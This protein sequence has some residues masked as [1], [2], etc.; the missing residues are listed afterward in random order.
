MDEMKGTVIVYSR[1][2]CK[3]S[4][5]AKNTLSQLGL[6]YLDISLDAFPKVEE[7]LIDLVGGS[8]QTP[9]IFF[10][11]LRVSGYRDLRRLVASSDA[12]LE[13]LEMLERGEDD[14]STVETESL[15]TNSTSNSNETKHST[16]E[17]SDALIPDNFEKL[18]THMRRANV[19]KNFT[20][21]SA[22]QNSFKAQDFIN[23]IMKVHEINKS[24]AFEYGQ[25]LFDSHLKMQM[26]NRNTTFN[27][28]DLYFL[29]VDDPHAPL[30]YVFP[31]MKK[32]ELYISV[33]DFNHKF[34]G[35][36]NRIYKQILSKDKKIVYFERLEDNENY[37]QYLK[38]ITDLPYVNLE[39][40]TTTE[41][42]AFFINIYNMMLVHI[43]YVNGP[44]TNIWQR[45]RYFNATYYLISKHKFSLQS[46]Y[47]G[48]LRG[49]RTGLN[50]LWKPFG[51]LDP[52]R[53][54]VVVDGNPFVH[55]AL[56]SYFTTTPQIRTYSVNNLD[57]EL[58]ENARQFLE[59]DGNLLVDTKTRSIVLNK[60]FKWFA[61][62]F[63]N[64]D[65]CIE[66]ISEVIEDEKLK[67]SLA[68]VFL[69]GQY[70]VNFLPFK[71]DLNFVREDTQ[72]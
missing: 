28:N 42:T 5:Q 37:G 10:N 15:S 24:E 26:N 34:C 36:V 64:Q 58:R 14:E 66:W 30:N 16:K 46:I 50:M 61:V 47:N 6:P 59:S 31:D 27:L 19:V 70:T 7:Q 45:R 53:S 9:Q 40:A 56:N 57:S 20:H 2:G 8:V 13:I 38:L 60:V 55:F 71:F 4:L 51:R 65:Q 23:W 1:I 67:E 22:H 62:D 68:K 11:S 49:N 21:G 43:V 69:S 35:I 63:G 44:H 17:Q 12:W 54:L 39:S 72:K 33:S 32:T 52:R 3:S 48:I 18:L 25:R 41:R 29:N